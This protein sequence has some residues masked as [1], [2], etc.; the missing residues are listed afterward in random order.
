MTK[1]NKKKFDPIKLGEVSTKICNDIVEG[2]KGLK[3][4]SGRVFIRLTLETEKDVFY[5][6]DRVTKTETIIEIQSIEK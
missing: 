3:P 2:M 5:G 6:T 1:R 4:V